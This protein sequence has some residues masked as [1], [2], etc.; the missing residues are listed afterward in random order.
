MFDG[1]MVK[2]NFPIIK[3]LD[4]KF[5]VHDRVQDKGPRQKLDLENF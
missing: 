5:L 1:E 3:V 2:K 4:R